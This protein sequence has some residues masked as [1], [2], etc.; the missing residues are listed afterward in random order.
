MYTHFNKIPSKGIGPCTILAEERLKI[1]RSQRRFEGLS[2]LH[3]SPIN[4]QFKTW[5]L[6]HSKTLLKHEYETNLIVTS[7]SSI[8][9]SQ[10]ITSFSHEKTPY[11]W[12]FEDMNDIKS[13]EGV[14]LTRERLFLF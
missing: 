7:K 2:P 3:H 4:Q 14:D 10:D 5:A 6:M 9:P 11:I 13:W 8:V 12:A 1:I